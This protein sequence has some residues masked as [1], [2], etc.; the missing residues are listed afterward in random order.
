MKFLFAIFLVLNLSITRI[1]SNLA[2]SHES[3]HSENRS[4]TLSNLT[5][6]VPRNLFKRIKLKNELVISADSKIKHE[7]LNEFLTLKAY[8]SY[9]KILMISIPQLRITFHDMI[10]I[11]DG[12]KDFESTRRFI[13]LGSTGCNL[14]DIA[15]EQANISVSVCPWH[16]EVFQR[17]DRYPFR[18]PIARCNCK[19]CQAKTIYDS[20]IYRLSS[21]RPETTFQPV[22]YRTYNFNNTEKWSFGVEAVPIACVCAIKLNP[23]A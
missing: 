11:L 20:D 3:T 15:N 7:Q 12:E 16:W 4:K 9:D 2:Q 13:I 17:E 18:R 21:C 22:L 23:Q 14:E 19:L 10:T 5:D 6:H 8:E 1:F